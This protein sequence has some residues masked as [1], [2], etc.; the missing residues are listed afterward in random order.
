MFLKT[1]TYNLLT[2]L[3]ALDCT[4]TQ[5]IAALRSKKKLAKIHLSIFAISDVVMHIDT[6]LK[7]SYF[8]VN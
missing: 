8:H 2:S 7:I 5:R 1:I 4:Y 3:G 6:W